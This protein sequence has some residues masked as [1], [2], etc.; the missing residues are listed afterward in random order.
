MRKSIGSKLLSALKSAQTGMMPN[1]MK[2]PCDRVMAAVLPK[3]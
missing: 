2:R 3:Q 1:S